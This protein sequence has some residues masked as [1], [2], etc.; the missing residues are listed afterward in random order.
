MYLPPGHPII[1]IFQ[2]IEIK[3]AA[4]SAKRSGQ[5]DSAM[6]PIGLQPYLVYL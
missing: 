4:E 3:M 1:Y 5:M 6:R 2:T